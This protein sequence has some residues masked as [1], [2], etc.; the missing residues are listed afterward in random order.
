MGL[1][2][3]KKMPSTHVPTAN[4]PAS[5]P[6]GEES[7]NEIGY[8]EQLS[9]GG[10]TTAESAEKMVEEV[11]KKQEQTEPTKEVPTE[12]NEVAYRELPVCMSQTQINN[13]VIENNIMLKQIISNI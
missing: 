8:V 10:Q 3:K 13:L 4:L 12:T 6:E 9:S 11:I 2:N 1:F 5:A 7:N